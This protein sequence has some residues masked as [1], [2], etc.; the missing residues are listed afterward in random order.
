MKKIF[1]R[2][3]HIHREYFVNH[4][5][6]ERLYNMYLHQTI[7]D[8]VLDNL[9]F[10]AIV[11]TVSHLIVEHFF[12]IVTPML[13]ILNITS[14]I[15]LAIFGIDLIRHYIKAKSNRD[16]YTHHGLDVFL[17]V[18][19]SLYF[20]FFTYFEI[21]RFS[22]MTGIKPLIADLKPLV[23]DLKYVRSFQHLFS[24]E[25]NEDEKYK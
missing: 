21:F 22:L 19:L 13:T 20:L 3:K 14:K 9:V 12:N 24:K 4:T 11:F 15:V 18:F 7:F 2:K 17:V 6:L 25:H 10:F 8:R 5:H 23:Y 1:K 16:F